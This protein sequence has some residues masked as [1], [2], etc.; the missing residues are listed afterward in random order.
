MF[1]HL[2]ETN[3]YN[4]LF[5]KGDIVPSFIHGMTEKD[6][7]SF[8]DDKYD[9]EFFVNKLENSFIYRTSSGMCVTVRRNTES[10]VN[11]SVGMYSPD[12]V[13]LIFNEIGK[14]AK[15]KH[16]RCIQPKKPSPA[17]FVHSGIRSDNF[18]VTMD[19]YSTIIVKCDHGTRA[20]TLVICGD[21]VVI[22]GVI[23]LNGDH[24]AQHPSWNK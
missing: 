19:K 7:L 11:V 15:A 14:H 20:N 24:I 1:T 12:N 6:T 23:V 17:S 8:R 9:N 22:L 3:D 4:N 2:V 21:I 10:G 18:S 16:P 13:E 5:F